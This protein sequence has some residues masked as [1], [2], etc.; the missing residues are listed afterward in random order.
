MLPP[1]FEGDLPDNTQRKVMLKSSSSTDFMHYMWNIL[2]ELGVKLDP[3]LAPPT[4]EVQLLA[5][6]VEKV[7]VGPPLW[8][9][10]S[11]ALF[12]DQLYKCIEAKVTGDYSK[13]AKRTPTPTE[14]PSQAPR[15]KN[16]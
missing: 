10:H 12:Y 3:I 6:G 5:T 9:T 1:G 2:A 7:R 15:Y 11:A 8:V 4:Y 14:L 13:F 16:Q